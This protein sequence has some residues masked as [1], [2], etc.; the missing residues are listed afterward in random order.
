VLLLDEPTNYLDVYVLEALED[1][2]SEFDGTLV[3]VS[4]DRYFREKISTRELIVKDKKIEEKIKPEP[5]TPHSTQKMLLE[6]EKTDL[7]CRLTSP[8][9][10]DVREDLEKR[11]Q[12]VC[13]MLR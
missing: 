4:H 1:M 8:R 10:G 6:M 2:L 13:E 12:E 9:K 11:Y 7:I 3:F 5:K